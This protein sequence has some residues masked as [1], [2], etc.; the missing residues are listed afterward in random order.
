MSR[1]YSPTNRIRF[2][3]IPEKYAAPRQY[4][5]KISDIHS[6]VVTYVYEH[7]KDTKKYR[8]KVLTFLIV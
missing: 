4:R 5:A 3:D 7:Y 8:Q 1:I 6:A 2:T